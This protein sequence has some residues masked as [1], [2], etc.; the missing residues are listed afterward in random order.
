ML[1]QPSRS[2]LAPVAARPTSILP[3]LSIRKHDGTLVTLAVGIAATP[4]S[5]AAGLSGRTELAPSAGLLFVFPVAGSI[6]FWMHDTVIPLSIAFVD[7]A[8]KITDLQEM[9]PLTDTRHVP[10]SPIRYAIEANRG[11]FSGNGIAVGDDVIL[12]GIVDHGH[13]HN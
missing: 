12:D 3:R 10:P 9:A 6:A 5:Q 13:G 8:Q 11:F 7:D 4:E 1:T 2:I